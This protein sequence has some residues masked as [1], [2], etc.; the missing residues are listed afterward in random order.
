MLRIQLLGGF[1]I[2]TGDETVITLTV[3]RLQSL[4]AYLVLHRETP[5]LRQHL[6]FLF[7][8]DSTEAQ[9]R[10]NLRHALHDLRQ[11]LPEAEV[12]LDIHTQS[13]QWRPGSAFTLDITEFE[14]A[15][16]EAA[17]WLLDQQIEPAVAAWTRAIDLYRGPFL[18]SCYD[19]W[20][21]AKREELGQLYSQALDHLIGL[22]ESRRDYA[23]AIGYAKRLL[24]HEPLVETAYQHLIRLQALQGDRA[25]ALHVYHE[26][27]AMLERELGV[28]PSTDT[29]TAYIQL[30]KEDVPTTLPVVQPIRT[31]EPSMLIGREVEWQQLLLTWQRIN[32]GHAQVVAITGEAGIG[33]TR[34]AETFVSWVSRQK[35]RAAFVR[36]YEAVGGLAFA[37]LPTP[38]AHRAC[39]RDGAAPALL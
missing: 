30:F 29:R 23:A 22:L 9:A 6:A 20:A 39:V 10:T 3:P 35:Q 21:L 7:W 12:Y 37:P 33:K 11:V 8:P 15:N 36:A 4:L 31:G 1:H 16:A 26:C 34:L 5:Q 28:E 27:V 18:T 13:I 19:D 32:Q 17:Q 38:I 14:T 24:H 25:S 2:Q